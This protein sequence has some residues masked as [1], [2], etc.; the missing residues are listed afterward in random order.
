[1]GRTYKQCVGLY[2]TQKNPIYMRQYICLFTAPECGTFCNYKHPLYETAFR[3]FFL[4]IYYIHA[5]LSIPGGSL[6]FDFFPFFLTILV[7]IYRC[8][9]IFFYVILLLNNRRKSSAG[10]DSSGKDHPVYRRKA[11]GKR[12]D[13]FRYTWVKRRTQ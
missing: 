4:L 3:V 9:E 10:A 11:A 12:L 5:G 6:K 7:F 8:C 1:M 2:C 13:R